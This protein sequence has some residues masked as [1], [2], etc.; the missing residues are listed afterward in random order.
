MEEERERER[1]TGKGTGRPI[2]Q[3]NDALGPREGGVS[4][5]RV[6]HL[7]CSRVEENQFPCFRWSCVLVQRSTGVTGSSSRSQ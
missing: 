1:E 2:P 7:V 3:N 6:E 5:E 4:R